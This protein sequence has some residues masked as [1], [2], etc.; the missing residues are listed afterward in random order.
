MKMRYACQMDGVELDSLAPSL[1][2]TDIAEAAPAADHSVVALAGGGRRILRDDRASLVVTV[3]FVIREY[4][5]TRRK[6]VCQAVAAWAQGKHLSVNDRPGQRLRV[7]CSKL[8]VVR[9][10]LRWT[11]SLSVEFTAW[12]LPFWESVQ[13]AQVARSGSGTAELRFPGTMADSPLCAKLTASG[14]VNRVVIACGEQ[15]YTLENLGMVSGDV[16]TIGQDDRGLQF[17]RVNDRSVLACRTTDSSD[18]ILLQPQAGNVIDLTA[19]GSVAA[20]FSA[21]GRWM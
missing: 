11:D 8:P 21:R 13:E 7:A 18:E 17:M 14:S 2:V 6:A 1:Y 20:V 10:A 5:V 19:D 4:D 15:R 12:E 16:L 3:T 9:S